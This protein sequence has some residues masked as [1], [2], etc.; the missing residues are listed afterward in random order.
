[1][2]PESLKK[3]EQEKPEESPPPA[4]QLP[5]DFYRRIFVDTVRSLKLDALDTEEEDIPL[6]I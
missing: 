6:F 2:D 4:P 3:I 1:M 5:I